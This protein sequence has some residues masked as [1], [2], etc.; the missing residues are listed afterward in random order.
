MTVKILHYYLFIGVALHVIFAP[1]VGYEYLDIYMFNVVSIVIYYIVLLLIKGLN[2]GDKKIV[3]ITVFSYSIL[4]VVTLNFISFYTTGN[5]YVFSDVD[6]IYYHDMAIA[7]TGKDIFQSINYYIQ[8]VNFDDL[9]MVIVLRV[10]YSLAESNLLFNFFNIVIGS[11]ISVLI[12]SICKNIMNRKMA[13]LCAVS[14][15]ISSYMLWFYSSGLKE[16]FM[17]LVIVLSFHQYYNG[18][19]KISNLRLY[20]FPALLLVFRPAITVFILASI[21]FRRLI[22]DRYLINK[23]AI[24]LVVLG[25]VSF[26]YSFLETYVNNITGG[27]TFE[28]LVY[29]KESTGQIKGSIPFVYGVNAIAQMMGPLPTVLPTYSP[30]A[31]YSSGLFFRVLLAFPFWYG[32][33]YVIRYGEYYLLPMVLFVLFEMFS[34]F[35]I[36]EGL[37]LRKSL[38]HLP[39][40]YIISFWF[41]D[42]YKSMPSNRKKRIKIMLIFYSIFVTFIL[43]F[44]NLR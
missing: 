36:F 44:W 32:V 41:M 31:F 8:R 26:F 37:E 38:P 13:A 12:F 9:G 27:G 19:R 10:V 5:Y 18:H 43:I 20:I 24:L 3:F 11:T 1:W 17:L 16:S 25:G 15:G 23:I 22:A 33:L 40:V 42:T 30:V 7:G 39:F 2:I 14:Y 35:I 29:V 28:T 4:A 6:A 21:F 34:L